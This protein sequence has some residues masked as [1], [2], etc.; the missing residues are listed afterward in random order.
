M[1]KYFSFLLIALLSQSFLM[2]QTVPSPKSHFG[3]NIGDNYQLATFTQTEAYLK[4]LAAVSKKVKLQIIGKTEEG[5]NHYMVIVSDPSNL[6]NLEK[7]KTI[8]QKLAH[9]EDLSM[10]EATQMANEGKAVVWIDGGLHA[11]E[12]TGI[13]QWIESMYQLITRTD[14][15]TKRILKS[16]IILFVHANPDGQELVSNWY[17]RNSDTLKRTTSSLPRLYQ[18]YIGHDNNRD[19]YMT[20]MQE[21]KNMSR[22]QYIEWMPQVLYNHHQTGPPGTVVAGPPYRDPFNYV[23]D[24]LLITGIDALGAAM[25]SRLN[26]ESKPGYTMKS[27]SVYSTWWN[28]G[29]RTT[30][31]YH[32]IIGLLTEIIGNPTP[33]NIPLVPQRLIPNSAT[34]YPITPQKWYFRNSIDYSVSLNYA[35]LNYAARYREELLLNIYK[36]GRHSIEAG[37]KDSWTLYPKRSDAVAELLKTEK[38]TGNIDSFQTTLFNKVYKNPA[39]RDA[40]GYIVTANQTTTAI[41]F[42]NILI[43]SGIKVEK[44][45]ANF[46]VAGKNYPAGS[47]IVKTNQ[48]FRPHVI[49][50]FEPQDHPNDFQYP[51]GPPVRP[52]DAAGW[53]PA[54]T[55]GI[56]FDRILDDFNGPFET[57]PYGL[58]QKPIG[59]INAI[60]TVAGYSFSTKENAAYYA[61][62][63]L[64]AMGIEVYKNK[65]QYF[66][67]ANTNNKKLQETIE[68]LSA[69]KGII[70]NGVTARPTNMNDKIMPQRIA[71]WDKYGGS[72]SSGWVRWIFEKYNFPFQLIYAKEIDASNLKEKYDVILFVEGAI[73]SL[74]LEA[75][76]GYEE[77]EPKTEDVP[78]IYQASLGKITAEKS[79]PALNTFLQNGGTIITI[80]SSA[81]LAYHLN[82]PVRNA[83]VEMVAGKEKSL[84]GEKFY[85]PGSVMQITLDKEYK[86]NWG[87]NKNADVY[88]SASPVFKLLPDAI[89]R[90]EVI[91]LAWYASD[92]TL[93][94]GWAF[95][96]SYLQD[97]IAAFEAKVGAG[98]LFVY[99]PEIT[100]RGQTHSN[101]KMLFNQLYK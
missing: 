76:N 5:R 88:F 26:A 54:F 65:D 3:F 16:T 99:G 71:L 10:A 22:Q 36:M 60:A 77:K 80:G 56:E 43:Q 33:S 90:K 41:D 94:S 29:L 70:F 37:N 66:V 13:H 34:P 12:V 27:G 46:S 95:G 51:G 101:Y 9:A 58:I 40:R 57:I 69:E 61:I 81:N 8:S 15:E 18:K 87:M 30:A 93:R 42:I 11:T 89:A 53:T 24:P 45:N 97:G 7:Y 31:Y 85:I 21:S 19:F 67:A 6:A 32:N 64:L 78:E 91:P 39:N 48:A 23:Y 55:M 20:N 84:P 68:S 28:G 100:F 2:A 47:Y 14:E 38:L 98:K 44:A 79:I 1:R 74:K 82:V 86:A 83:L 63:T 62:N 17:M 50:M 59:K 75:G 72:M 92:K 96:Q 35:V 25:S 73:P 52:Y 4:K 49:D